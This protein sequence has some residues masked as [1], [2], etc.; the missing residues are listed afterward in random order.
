MPLIRKTLGTI[1]GPYQW[2]IGSDRRPFAS[3]WQRKLAD[4]LFTATNAIPLATW[5]HIAVVF[6][7]A[8]VY[9][10]L[11]GSLNGSLSVSQLVADGGL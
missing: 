1:A 11:N 10:Y 8:T 5:T 6:D 4:E 3:I 2:A 7:G 9:H